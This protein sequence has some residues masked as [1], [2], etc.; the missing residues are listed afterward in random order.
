[1]KKNK[2]QVTLL[3]IISS[4]VL[5]LAL[6][7]LWLTNSYEQAYF[8]IRRETNGLFRS[9]IF[10]MRDSLFTQRISPLYPDSVNQAIT[11]DRVE[12][13][14]D[15]ASQVRIYINAQN[16]KA[17]TVSTLL[18]PIAGRLHMT[19]F[20]QGR[21]FVIRITPDSLSLD[22]IQYQFSRTLEQNNVDVHFTVQTAKDTPPQM[23]FR[24]GRFRMAEAQWEDSLT[25][26][27]Y[28]N[29]LYSDWVRFDPAHRYSVI[30][31]GIRPL[32]LKQITPQ[33]LFSLFLTIITTAAFV[34]MYR[35]LRAQQRV[36][37]L[38]N[39][40]ISNITH[41]LKTPVTTVSVAL[42]AIKNFKGQNNPEL[43]TE[44]LEIAQNELNRLN[45]LTDK[46]LKT[47]IFEDKGVAYNAEPVDVNLL[48]SQVLN[49]MKL[50]FEKQKAIV[51]YSCKGNDFNLLGGAAHLT[52]VVYNLL[53][54]ALKYSP[55]NPAITI[56]LSEN[57]EEI[58]LRIKDNG[59][60]IAPEYK[61]K[62][63]EKF[64]RVPT[65]DVHN[66]KGYGLGLSYVDSVV[67]SHNG[68]I[69]VESEP[70]K[71]SEFIIRLPKN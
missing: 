60:G 18:R 55:A 8:D 6:Q 33:I 4:I 70:G 35:S 2:N 62:V 14:P 15:S 36:M 39:D 21:S 26:R 65:G 59:I 30:L 24:P 66:I 11:P 10:A 46:I 31:S 45:I 19:Q 52:S 17:D 16:I 50:V 48:V 64:F 9:T 29:L 54:N 61:K 1:M 57:K 3:L 41:E 53:D 13:L 40:F 32:L 7:A 47:A 12:K 38:K 44:Y 69:T 28:S 51:S 27:I 42:E 43:T 34:M 20:L 37:D 63:F 5:L 49:S 68:T 56:S 71:G 23:D 67:K 25:K 58:E 22:S